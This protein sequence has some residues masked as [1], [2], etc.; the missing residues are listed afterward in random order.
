[1]LLTMSTERDTEKSAL[2][3]EMLSTTSAAEP[4]FIPT[5][6]RVLFVVSPITCGI[7]SIEE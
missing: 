7:Y 4:E 1:M 2:A 3:T 5:L 6:K